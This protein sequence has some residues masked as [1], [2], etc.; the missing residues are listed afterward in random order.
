[1]NMILCS[2]PCRHQRD[3][4]CSLEGEGTITNAAINGCCYFAPRE[5][6]TKQ[7]GEKY[8]DTDSKYVQDI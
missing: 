4:V 8:A 5:G 7:A 1:M 6:K 3:G 2:E